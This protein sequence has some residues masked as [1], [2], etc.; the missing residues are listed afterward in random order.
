[1]E[2]NRDKND[3]IRGKGTFDNVMT[4]LG[5][6]E[7][8]N[9]RRWM[10]YTVSRINKDAF[11]DFV[12]IAIET[13]CFGN[14]ITPYTGDE[15]LMLSFNEWVDFKYN[16]LSYAEKRGAF[17]IHSKKSCGFVYLCSEYRDGIT[18]NPDGTFTGCARNQDIT[19]PYKTMLDYVTHDITFIHQACMKAKWSD[20]HALDLLKQV[21]MKNNKRPHCMPLSGS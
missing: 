4:A 13:N 9:I 20:S 7:D 8:N 17:S 2:G 15:E 3:E 12:N 19:R 5:S 14:N 21:F 10:S 6:L 11:K 16:L 1:M 18:I